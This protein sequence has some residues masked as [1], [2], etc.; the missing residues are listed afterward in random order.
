MSEKYNI[1]GLFDKVQSPE[2]LRQEVERKLVPLDPSLFEPYKQ[3]AVPIEQVYLSRPDEDYTLRVRASYDPSGEVYTATL[4]NN[5]VMTPYGMSRLEI[6]TPIDRET[7]LRYSADPAYPRVKK[8]RTELTPGVTIDWIAGV[9]LPLIE[10]EGSANCESAAAFYEDYQQAMID[11]TGDPAYDNS[12]IAYEQF[13]GNF[14]PRRELTVESIVD[15]MAAQLHIG[16]E[17]VVVGISG[18][19][20]S[21]KTTLANEVE[22][23][24][25]SRFGEDLPPAVRLST[26]DYHRGKTW[27]E[28][29][30]G[31]PWTNWDAPEVYDTASL[32]RDVESL[33]TGNTIDK[34]YF[35]FEGEETIIDGTLTP[36]PF[37]IIEGIF[38][39]SPDLARVRDLHFNVPTPI[40]T[41]VGR[42]LLR[43]MHSDRPNN[44][45]SSPEARLRYQLETAIPTYEAQERPRRNTWSGSV[46]P[47]GQ[48]ALRARSESANPL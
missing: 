30:Y 23:E 7:F 37:V 13:G 24:L 14:E 5:G 39:G 45:I 31:Q 48:V 44:S 42:D 12:T 28:T 19:S 36:A 4:K 34:K 27:L 18:M 29:T 21:G 32:A 41:T 25:L 3:L 17:R 9:E 1:S 38:A 40:A 15:E 22:L 47:I 11:V 43:L 46:R 16:K 6:E 26:D 20:G 8:L 33:L 10:V 2:I 35:D